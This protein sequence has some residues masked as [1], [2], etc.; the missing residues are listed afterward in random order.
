MERID[1]ET[2]LG[3]FRQSLP[4][5]VV[6]DRTDHRTNSTDAIWG[7]ARG[8]AGTS[9]QAAVRAHD[10]PRTWPRFVGGAF[11]R[12]RVGDRAD[13]NTLDGKLIPSSWRSGLP[14]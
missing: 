4:P 14:P 1:V 11:F 2:R 6:R 9:I 5:V 7:H 10:D 13:S 8:G 12:A 3:I